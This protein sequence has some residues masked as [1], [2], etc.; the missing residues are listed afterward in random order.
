MIFHRTVDIPGLRT[1]SEA[2]PK[3]AGNWREHAK[4]ARH[5]AARGRGPEGCRH[6]GAAATADDVDEAE[7]SL[8]GG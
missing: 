8:G 3:R 7:G 6:A 2:N 5:Q 1:E 4:R